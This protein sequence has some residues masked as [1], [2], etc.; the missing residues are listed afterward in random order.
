MPIRSLFSLA[1]SILLAVAAPGQNA[2]ATAKPQAAPAATSSAATNAQAAEAGA[3]RNSATYGSGGAQST[4]QGGSRGSG[5]GRTRAGSQAGAQGGV[6]SQGSGQSQAGRPGITGVPGYRAG[7]RGP[8][9]TAAPAA[10]AAV[11]VTGDNDGS[12]PPRGEQSVALPGVPVLHNAFGI[13]KGTP[14]QVRLQQPVDSGHAR[15]GDTVHGTLAAPIGSAPAGAPV[16][17]TVVAVAAAGQMSS[18]GEL[19][20]QV[21]SVNG[22]RVLSDVITA[23]GKEGT[24]IMPDDAPGRGTEAIFTPDQPLTLPAG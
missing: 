12:A 2:P 14:I 7:F 20:L 17:L 8:R 4:T 5:A 16:Q 3:A 10:T 11:T 19:S 18:N 1:G 21:V 6:Q 13:T 15:N 24:R 22:E 9:G 23:E